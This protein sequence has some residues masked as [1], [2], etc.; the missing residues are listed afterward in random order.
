MDKTMIAVFDERS[1]AK[2]AIEGLF[3]AGFSQSEVSLLANNVAGDETID[4]YRHPGATGLETDVVHAEH[5]SHAAG[6]GAVTGGVLG[7]LAGLLLGM[8]SLAVPG[9]GPVVVAGPVAGLLAGALGGAVVGGLVGVL[10]EMGV[11]ENDAHTYS[12]AVRRG[13]TVVA[14][15]GPESKVET[16]AE[17]FRRFNPIDI[18]KRSE[19]WRNDGWDR[20]DHT[21]DPLS[22]EAIVEERTRY[23]ASR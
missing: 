4:P 3:D 6:T 15:T 18:Q 17:V 20:F 2:A 19:T 13:N 22:R 5:E 8:G 16:V 7:G 11:P 1:Q 12:E 9:V 21:T 23:V 10:V 14:V